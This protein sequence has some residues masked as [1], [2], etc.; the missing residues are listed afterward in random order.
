MSR[1]SLR[2]MRG[3]ELVD[4]AEDGDEDGENGDEAC[5]VAGA[6]LLPRQP[7]G[8]DQ[9]K[10]TTSGKCG[11]AGL[12]QPRGARKVRQPHRGK[13]RLGNLRRPRGEPT[14]KGAGEREQ[15]GERNQRP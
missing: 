11:K 14:E 13:V 4:D 12:T 10:R 6:W 8:G 9:P 7:A 2:A 5:V 1:R 15:V 3:V